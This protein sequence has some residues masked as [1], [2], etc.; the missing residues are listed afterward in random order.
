MLTSSS[1]LTGYQRTDLR[2]RTVKAILGYGSL[3][4]RFWDAVDVLTTKI[5][6]TLL[7][8]VDIIDKN[9]PEY[10]DVSLRGFYQDL[11][12]IVAEAGFFSLTLRESKDIFR[13]TWPFPGQSWDLDQHNHDDEVYKKSLAEN[14]RLYEQ[15]QREQQEQQQDEE[16]SNSDD[17]VFVTP[18]SS[19]SLPRATA[20][21]L[22]LLQSLKKR[23]RF[24]AAPTAPPP[25]P[26][27][28]SAQIAK[29][30]ICLWPQLQRFSTPTPLWKEPPNRPRDLYPEPGHQY[31]TAIARARVVYYLGSTN[32][33]VEQAERNPTLA[34]HIDARRSRFSLTRLPRG[35]GD[36]FAA[37]RRV[38]WLA[39]GL[40]ALLAIAARF[41]P[42]AQGVLD[43]ILDHFLRAVHAVFSF[44]SPY[45]LKAAN[46]LGQVALGLLY[47]VHVV[48]NMVEHVIWRVW[49]ILSAVVR[50]VVR[51]VREAATDQQ[52]PP[53]QPEQ[54][55]PPPPL[56]ETTSAGFWGWFR[57]GRQGAD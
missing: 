29:V 18:P 55:P 23:V 31:I 35:S 10:R 45:I 13:F 53:P 39:F 19:A 24:T 15:Q 6:T 11:H 57:A 8:L 40:F 25:P 4:V 50:A 48:F 52:Q 47:C 54:A 41:S 17:D 7:P 16:D 5:A 44:F 20:N 30:H 51:A 49:H 27:D 56:E 38:V 12:Y 33:V 37:I 2:G 42:L 1:L 3:P 34:Q 46:L 32:P 28:L 22:Q 26:V 14:K 9:F 43:T 21:R 36:S